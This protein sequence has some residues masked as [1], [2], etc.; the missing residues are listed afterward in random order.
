MW[1]IGLRII[2][3]GGGGGEMLWW[4]M[5]TSVVAWPVAKEWTASGNARA[6]SPA[7]ARQTALP[8]VQHLLI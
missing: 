7:E 2:V 4:S 5:S 6:R 1:K 3:G 8:I